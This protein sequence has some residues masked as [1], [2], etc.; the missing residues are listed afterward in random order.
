[1]ARAR[2]VLSRT[3]MVVLMANLAWIAWG[4]GDD[5]NC[6]DGSYM[7]CTQSNGSAGRKVCTGGKW[8]ACGSIPGQCQDG[9][10][11]KCTTADKKEGYQKCENGSWST[12][13]AADPP[14][15]KDGQKQAC[16]TLCGTGTEVCVKGAFVNC[17]APKPQQEVCDGT[18]NNCD[19]KIDEVCNCVHGKCEACYTGVPATT[20]GVGPCKAGQRCCTKGTWGKCENEVLPE[21]K[22]NCT[23]SID[24]DC[25]G[26]VNDGCTCTIGTKAPCGTDEGECKKGEKVCKSQRGQAVWGECV[27]GVT[28]I[29]EKGKGCDGKDNDCNGIIDDGLDPDSNE[30]NNTCAQAR[31]YTVQDSD[32]APKELT[33]TI[34]PKGDVDYFKIIA[35][36]SGKIKIPPCCPWPLCNPPDK[37]CHF[38]DVEVIQP[39]GVTGLKYQFS[40]F[41]GKC[42]K[43]VQTFVS[44][45]KKSF[46]WSGECGVDDSQTYWLKVEPITSSSPPFSCKPYK[47]RIRYTSTNKKC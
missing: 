13:D 30:A 7:D 41:T 29:P 25:N 40:L 43:P 32:S 3:L 42:D 20:K 26:T 33:L 38:L 1:M 45:T 46:S 12:C 37:Q 2:I 39:A 28:A 6:T 21:T 36:E 14:A 35:S 19:G 44:T 8:T 16:S 24:N 5:V 15:C 4:C 23:D 27:G 17:D 18:D 9:T 34:Y 11:K 10:Y 47:V 22:E 31:S